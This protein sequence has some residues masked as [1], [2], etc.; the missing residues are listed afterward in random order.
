[1]NILKRLDIIVDKYK[2]IDLLEE[3][4]YV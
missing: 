1:M 2:I 3:E 4:E